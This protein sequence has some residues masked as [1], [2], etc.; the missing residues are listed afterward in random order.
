MDTKNLRHFIRTPLSDT[1]YIQGVKGNLQYQILNPNGD[2]LSFVSDGNPQ[3]YAFDTDECISL[4]ACN[5][6]E[7]QLNFLKTQGLIP[8]GH[9][10]FFTDNGYLI[11]GQFQL[12]ER[13]SAIL[14]GTSINGNGFQNV[15]QGFR[16]N[17]ILPRSKLNYTFE[18]SN[19]FLTQETMC[20][21]YYNPAVITNE[22]KALALESLKYIIIQWEFV[23][24]DE[25]NRPSID[26]TIHLNSALKQAPLHLAIPACPSW[27]SGN[28]TACG[29]K[30]PA[31][32]VMLCGI[33][34]NKTYSIF[35]QYVSYHKTLSADYPIPYCCKGTITV[36]NTLAT[37]P[38]ALT[39][40]QKILAY[41]QTIYQSLQSAKS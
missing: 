21:D 27:N 29:D 31:H 35:D 8:Q 24:N 19:K 40:F 39:W 2:W 14:N 18:Q 28:V 22:M 20:Q 23:V 30:K 26:D 38:E 1:D 4:S 17:G 3:K 37:I 34:A 41:F 25:L 7:T 6:L 32:G 33:N 5:I 36:N 11:N 10:K 9:L 12:S 16:K 15:W 13:F